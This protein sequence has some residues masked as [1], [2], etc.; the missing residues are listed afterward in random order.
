MSGSHP[1]MAPVYLPGSEPYPPGTTEEEKDGYRQMVK[2][3]KYGGYAMES[4]ALKVVL[5]GGAG[6]FGAYQQQ[7]LLLLLP[8]RLLHVVSRG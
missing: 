8:L 1:L 7:Q 3:N 4:C 6:A 5:A 2:W